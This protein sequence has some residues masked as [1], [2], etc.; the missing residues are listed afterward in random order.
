MTGLPGCGKTTLGRRLAEL[1]G[2]QF[3]DKDDIL[4]SMLDEYS[5]FSIE[6]RQKLSRE[7][8]L[9]FQKQALLSRNSVLT[10]FWRAPKSDS[11][12]G[13]ASDWLASASHE[14]IEVLCQCDCDVAVER[15]LNRQRHPGHMD[16]LRNR[17]TLQSQ[18]SALAKAWPLGFGQLIKVDT[19]NPV[20]PDMIIQ[21]IRDFWP[22]S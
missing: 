14:I 15:F 16:H 18:F 3:I 13:T 21:Q 12:V 17:L 9:I 22:V 8:D 2:F 7:S 6:L 20:D 5:E 19:S 1:L 4:E 10:S 11:T